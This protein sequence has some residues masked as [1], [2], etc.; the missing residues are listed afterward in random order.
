L[1]IVSLRQDIVS[2]VLDIESVLFYICA[3]AD[4]TNQT[5]EADE[6]TPMTFDERNTWVFAVVAVGAYL[7]YVAVVLS[8]AGDGP[9]AKA[10]Y[11]KSMLWTI[12]GSVL[13][14]IAAQIVIS[15]RWPED[16][17][18]RDQRDEQINRFGEF[19]GQSFVV[20]GGIIALILSMLEVAHFWIANAIYL[21][22]VLSALLGS[23][24][25]LA[26]YRRGYHP[27]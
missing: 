8:S 10:P 19:I 12:G 25:K 13:V 26:A 1:D 23:L 11:V 9:L 6:P 16:A 5:G 22:F 14:S 18:R 7:A 15:M 17:G 3:M 2:D 20:I 21:C 4:E 27:W 24:A